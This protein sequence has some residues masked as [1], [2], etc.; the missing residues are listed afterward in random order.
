MR[1]S[2]TGGV[3]T[4]PEP[5]LALPSPLTCGAEP[6]TPMR[7]MAVR[8]TARASCARDEG[9][10]GS[11]RAAS[12]VR[13]P[14]QGRECSSEAFRQAFT[15][16]CAPR[17]GSV[18]CPPH[19]LNRELS[20][21]DEDTTFSAGARRIRQEGSASATAECSQAVQ[22]AA[23]ARR[24][25]HGCRVAR[26]CWRAPFLLISGKVENLELQM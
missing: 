25:P 22:S 15:A 3:H 13:R 16:W 11:C 14:A 17:V 7:E 18:P 21:K 6:L 12:C 20:A 2:D 8:A 19:T 9:C 24:M 23:A 1:S 26:L 10:V 4:F 5:L